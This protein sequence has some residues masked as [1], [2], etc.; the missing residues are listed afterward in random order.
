MKKFLLL[1]FVLSLLQA[2]RVEAE[3]VADQ[4]VAGQTDLNVNS[5]VAVA[6]VSSEDLAVIKAEYQRNRTELNSVITDLSLRRAALDTLQTNIDLLNSRFEELQDLVTK[7]EEQKNVA[8]ADLEKIKKTKE[9]LD[10]EIAYLKL[11]LQEVENVRRV[12]KVLDK[13]TSLSFICDYKMKDHVSVLRGNCDIRVTWVSSPDRFYEPSKFFIVERGERATNTVYE[14]VLSSNPSSNP[15]TLLAG[16]WRNEKIKMSIIYD[17]FVTYKRQSSDS[18]STAYEYRVKV[19]SFIYVKPVVNFNITGKL[20]TAWQLNEAGDSA[21]IFPAIAFGPQFNSK[22]MSFPLS[23]LLGVGP[24]I[25]PPRET[26]NTETGEKIVPDKTKVNIIF[27]IDFTL[28]KY[29]SMGVGWPLLGDDR[30]YVPFLTLGLGKLY[31]GYD[32][33]K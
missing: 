13:G 3:E 20:V 1:V 16:D 6:T 7:A 5:S 11:R 14:T 24:N 28:D 31:P 9:T 26:V 30:S 17:M 32:V 23:I 33:G 19:G 8:Q 2:F 4:P 29:L 22:K 25:I 15:I 18:A 21:F 27:G 12:Q 10:G